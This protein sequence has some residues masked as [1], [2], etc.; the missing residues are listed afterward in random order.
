MSGESEPHVVFSKAEAL[1]L[2]ALLQETR[3]V[4][5]LCRGPINAWPQ[6]RDT[7]VP[8]IDALLAES[9]VEPCS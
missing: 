9:K 6:H 3:T 7:L 8:R 1:E 5:A 4:L 2:A